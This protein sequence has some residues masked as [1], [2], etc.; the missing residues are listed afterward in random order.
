MRYVGIKGK[1]WL[2]VARFVKKRETGCYT[3]PARDL[4]G[5]NANAG[6]Y[7]PVALVGSNNQWSW[8]ERFI[9]TQCMRCNGPGEGMAHEFEANLRRELG[10]A[11]VDEFEANYRRVNPIKNFQE[12]IDRYNKLYEEL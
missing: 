2:A 6:H 7:K 10:D 11:A 4:Q 3:C 5:Q 9:H 1:A 8:D 12:V